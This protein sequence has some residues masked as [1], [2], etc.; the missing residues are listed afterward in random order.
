QG[1]RVA[2]VPIGSCEQHG[3]HLPLGSDTYFIYEA[4]R[5]G[6]ERA[7]EEAGQPV[8]LV[9]P[10]LWYSNG[11]QWAP[12]EVWLRPS[13]IIAVL[14]DVVTQIERHGF[15]QI[16]LTTGHG[17]NPGI[18]ADALR[19]AREGGVRAELFSVPPWAFIGETIK[20]VRETKK[21]GH[22]CEI[23]TSTS[24]YLFGDRVRT[25]RIRPGPEQPSYWAEISPYEAVRRGEVRQ[26]GVSAGKIGEHAGFVGDPSKATAAKGERLVDAW[27]AG[28]AAFLRE[29]HGAPAR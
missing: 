16:V 6:A 7:A 28:F 3:P 24:L 5:R 17:G 22:A 23:E 9:F 11:D 21:T 15:R 4:A 26:Q 2:V 12:G 27:A 19:E 25:D 18:M 13:T 14:V 20:E 8:A 10:P 29:L 1:C